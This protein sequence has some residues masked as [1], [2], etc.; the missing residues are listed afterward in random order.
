MEHHR[1][2]EQGIMAFMWLLFTEQGELWEMPPEFH[3]IHERRENM[4][5]TA[6]GYDVFEA[7]FT[8]HPHPAMATTLLKSLP[9]E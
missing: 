9:L 3:Y 2:Q 8:N 1:W 4:T 7:E 5:A 6:C